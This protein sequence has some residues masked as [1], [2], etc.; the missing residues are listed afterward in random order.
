ML[1]IYCGI[2][3]LSISAISSNANF[4]AWRRAIYLS[5]G[6]I[7]WILNTLFFLSL[8]LV[9]QMMWIVDRNKY[10]GGPVEYYNL[11]YASSS[12]V[13]LADAAQNL[14]IFLSDALLASFL[15]IYARDLN[16]PT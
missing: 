14:A 13:M 16:S 9:G 7:Q 8:P 4:V 3:C 11:Q 5:Y 6:V 15:H 2:I 12:Y 10:V 1:G